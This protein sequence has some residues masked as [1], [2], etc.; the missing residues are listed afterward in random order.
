[1]YSFPDLK[2]VCC[3]MSGSNCCFL[4]C[5]QISQET[6]QEVWY[7]CLFKNVTQFVVIHTVKG[8]DVVTKAEVEDEFLRCINKFVFIK[9]GGIFSYYFF[10]NLL[11]PFLSSPTET[12]CYAQDDMLGGGPEISEALLNFHFFS[13]VFR[14]DKL[15]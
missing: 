6:G 1:M 5:K 15:Y 2:P 11:C 12:P 13:I 3:S 7:S 9:L 8:L 10:K 14:L 4:T